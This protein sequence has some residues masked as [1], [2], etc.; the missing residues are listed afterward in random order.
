MQ[1]AVFS[2]IFYPFTMKSFITFFAIAFV[3]FVDAMSITDRISSHAI[4]EESA[5]LFKCL[6]FSQIHLLGFKL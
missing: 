3:F 5:I 2:L 4:T 1:N 6:L